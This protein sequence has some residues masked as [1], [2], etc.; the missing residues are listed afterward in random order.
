MT[1]TFFEIMRYSELREKTLKL[2][3]LDF[4]YSMETDSQKILQRRIMEDSSTGV[5]HADMSLTDLSKRWMELFKDKKSRILFF[6][7]NFR[8]L[9]K[10]GFHFLQTLKAKNKFFILFPQL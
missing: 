4:Q 2:A 7:A 6:F 5:L 3:Q 1:G 8:E 10:Q 9:K